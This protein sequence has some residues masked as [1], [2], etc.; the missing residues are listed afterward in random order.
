[1]S[2]SLRWLSSGLSVGAVGA[3]IAFVVSIFQFLSVR[4]RESREREFN[5]YHALIDR[6]VSRDG[7]GSLPLDRQIA[8]IFELRHFPRYYECTVR[9]LMGPETV[10]GRGATAFEAHRGNRFDAR[11][12]PAANKL[13]TTFCRVP[14][15]APV[16][17]PLEPR[18]SH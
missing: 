7:T 3:A 17:S 16:G 5:Q 12:Y 18:L 4:K 2:E 6:L 10:V 8:V 15:N 11:P 1:M 13:K 14:Q 9:I